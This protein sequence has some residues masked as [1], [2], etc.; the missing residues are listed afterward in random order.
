MAPCAFVQL[1]AAYTASDVRHS[2]N[3]L[4]SLMRLGLP[5]F[6]P[7]GSSTASELSLTNW[8]LCREKPN[9]NSNIE[10]LKVLFGNLFAFQSTE[11]ASVNE[12]RAALLPQDAL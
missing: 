6:H 2:L 8:K 5:F 3:L 7:A 9:W 12:L 1:T 4:P 10:L 11:G